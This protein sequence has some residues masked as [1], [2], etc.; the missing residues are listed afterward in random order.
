MK[1]LLIGCGR[2]G[3]NIS[4]GLKNSLPLGWLPLSH[5]EAMQSSQNIQV[6]GVCDL[7]LENAQKVAE[8]FK[9]NQF[10]DDYK[11]A[12]NSIH[13]DIISIA[14]RT[15]VRKEII[16]FAVANGVKGIHVE[17][18]LCNSLKDT[19]E[20]LNLLKEQKVKI[21]YGTY[22][23]YHY[24]YRQ[25]KQLIEAGRIGNL[26]EIQIH[27]GKSNMLWTQPHAADLLIFFSGCADIDFI[28]GHC[29]GELTSTKNTV[30]ADPVINMGYVKFTNG[31]NG[32]ITSSGGLDVV[33]SG[34]KGKILIK[35]DGSD[36]TL[37]IQTPD[38]YLLIEDSSFKFQPG[39]LSATQEAFENLCLD[40]QNKSNSN[41]KIEEILAS[42]QILFGIVQSHMEQ[43]RRI[44]VNELN[45][46][47]CVTGRSGELYA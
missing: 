26:V 10:F 13:P 3:A 40:V 4:D 30:D 16:L 20:V 33:I 1:A 42:Q 2:M 29:H 47:L 7:M 45:E 36:L 38:S 11:K 8:K 23:R 17:K 41:I 12:I 32:L 35:G 37:S 18:P 24:L 39:K 28:Q 34:D 9:V 14:T 46:N 5:V 15:S 6:E 21:S 27:H 19:K 44:K 25:A 22:R 43:G 31:V